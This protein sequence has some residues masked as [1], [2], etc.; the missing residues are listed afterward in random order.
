[1]AQAGHETRLHGIGADRKY[2]G[3]SRGR[4]FRGECRD[5][6]ASE[7][8]RDLP[9]NEFGRERRQSTDV[10]FCKPGFDGDIA[11]FVE[12]GF[13]QSFAEWSQQV[14]I[15]MGRSKPEITDDRCSR[16]LR[17]CG[18]RPSDRTADKRDELAPS[19]SRPRGSRLAILLVQ[20][21]AVSAPVMGVC[22]KTASAR[23]FY[24]LI[25]ASD[26]AEAKRRG[27]APWRS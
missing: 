26:Q 21:S 2:D 10:A 18:K 22:P 24:H 15:G 23:L 13:T 14:R 11:A 5:R 8:D 3:N 1:M 27:R 12:A 6:C 9:L 25:R 20:K 4:R 19:H 17:K 7:D 16:L